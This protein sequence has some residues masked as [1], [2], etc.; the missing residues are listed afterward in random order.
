ML[1]GY[2]RG[3]TGEQPKAQAH[4]LLGDINR[5]PSVPAIPPVTV[6]H[7]VEGR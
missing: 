1:I 7:S 6:Q 5:P 4:L 2:M 3:S